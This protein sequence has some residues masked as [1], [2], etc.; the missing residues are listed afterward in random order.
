MTT[1][2]R[3]IESVRDK[4]Y[5][6]RSAFTIEDVET[7][8]VHINKLEQRLES[9]ERESTRLRIVINNVSGAL[10]DED[11]A[12]ARALVG[13]ELRFYDYKKTKGER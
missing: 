3:D 7:L 5:N 1:P 4:Y 13:N 9:A 10:M 12:K 8:L 6:S 2:T 11:M